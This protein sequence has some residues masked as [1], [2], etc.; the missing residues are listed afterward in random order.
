MSVDQFHSIGQKPKFSPPGGSDAQNRASRDFGNTDQAARLSRRSRSSTVVGVAITL[1]CIR[2]R[3][4]SRR[5]LDANLEAFPEQAGSGSSVKTLVW[6]S[7]S[8][9]TLAKDPCCKRIPATLKLKIIIQIGPFWK[10]DEDAVPSTPHQTTCQICRRVKPVV[11]SGFCSMARVASEKSTVKIAVP[12]GGKIGNHSDEP[13][14]ILDVLKDRYAYD[15]I[16][17]ADPRRR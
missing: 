11:N 1:G 12:F 14:V 10:I 2:T 15:Q 6:T 16:I 8:G 9:D 3:L 4:S 7:S 13:L 17:E 5:V